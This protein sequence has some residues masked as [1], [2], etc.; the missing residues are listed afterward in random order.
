MPE[1]SFVVEIGGETAG[2]VLKEGNAFR[3]HAIG[4]P[5]F[6][7]DGTQFT[8]PGHA[9]FAVAPSRCWADG[10]PAIEIELPANS[11]PRKGD[12]LPVR[13]VTQ[14]PFALHPE[15]NR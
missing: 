7:L 1:Q 12:V 11:T 6:V 15:E 10:M 4:H 8:T 13:L 5:F 14:R 2:I 3:F 9:G